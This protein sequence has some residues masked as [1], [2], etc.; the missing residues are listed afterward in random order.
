MSSPPPSSPNDA[1]FRAILGVMLL[2]VIG[3]VALVLLGDYVWHN[4]AMKNVGTGA[5]LLG[6]FIYFFF[7]VLG[8]R[9][10]KRRQ[11]SQS[12]QHDNDGEPGD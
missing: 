3:G 10:A 1:I 11:D 5:V 9:E 8:K 2:T 4:E 7:R 6:G 12:S